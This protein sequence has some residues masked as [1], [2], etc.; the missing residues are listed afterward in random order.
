MTLS[1]R[2]AADRGEYKLGR[3][4]DYLGSIARMLRDLSGF[5]TLVYELLQNADDAPGATTA[6]F[7]ITPEALIVWNDGQ[8]SD[9]GS[10]E[11]HPDQCPWL[12]ERGERC[13]FHRFRSVSA[14]DKGRRADLT[15]AFGIGF[16][17]VY[18]IT[19]QPEVISSGQ[20]WIIDET[21]P[22]E[23]RI[24]VH[25]RC[26]VCDGETGTRFILPW[27]RD[28]NSDFR[29]RTNATPVDGND[30]AELVA[31]IPRAAIGSAMEVGG[32]ED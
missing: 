6:R 30:E 26:P 5:A 22:E 32:C 4:I 12:A 21:Q 29:Q 8:F 23:E 19:D 11:L 17:A 1:S 15:G 18:Q 10:Q 31:R 20:H 3:G 27:A 25:R 28:P 24:R 7:D 14:G 9:C 16:T 13:D 2:R